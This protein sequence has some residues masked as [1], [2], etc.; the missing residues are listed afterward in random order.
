[1]LASFMAT[2]REGWYAFPVWWLRQFVK[3]SIA[4]MTVAMLAESWEKNSIAFLYYYRR[5]LLVYGLTIY[6]DTHK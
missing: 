5:E 1:M 6:R 2:T 4:G 3:W